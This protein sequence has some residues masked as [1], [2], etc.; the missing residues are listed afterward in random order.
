MSSLADERARA[1]LLLKIALNSPLH[2]IQCMIV[3]ECQATYPIR[4][5]EIHYCS[6]RA[7]GAGTCRTQRRTFRRLRPDDREA[8]TSVAFFPGIDALLCWP[9]H[10]GWVATL[11][12]GKLDRVRSRLYRGKNLQENMRLKALAKIYTMRSFALL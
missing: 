6:T 5:S 12:T 1:K 11:A 2:S 3:L 4:N 9:K 10:R 7:H 8:E